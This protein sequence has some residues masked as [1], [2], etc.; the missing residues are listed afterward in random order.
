MRYEQ[1]QIRTVAPARFIV[2]CAI[3]TRSILLRHYR[4]RATV[5]PF[6]SIL[7]QV[8]IHLYLQGI[9][10]IIG[11]HLLHHYMRASYSNGQQWT[12]IAN[13]TAGSLGK[14]NTLANIASH[15][16]LR[17]INPNKYCNRLLPVEGNYLYLMDNIKLQILKQ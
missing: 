17:R 1:N 8:A 16:L 14:R 10:A 13:E 11:T 15:K 4:P 3:P 12:P 6:Y 5:L 9:T 2:L 7:R